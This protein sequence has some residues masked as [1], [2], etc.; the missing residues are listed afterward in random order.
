MRDPEPSTSA[1]SDA[2]VRDIRRATRV[3]KRMTGM[4]QRFA[5]RLSFCQQWFSSSEKLTH[6]DSKSATKFQI[7]F[8]IRS[9]RA[10]S[11][12]TCS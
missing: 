10:T 5:A 11:Y 8:V 4:R 1:L 9:L 12:S 2:E 6:F 7:S 3:K